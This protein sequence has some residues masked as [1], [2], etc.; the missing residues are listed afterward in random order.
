MENKQLIKKYALSLYQ[1]GK[2]EGDLD[3][4]QKGAHVVRGLYK[5]S[6]TFRYFLLTKK[7]ADNDKK[8]ILSDVLENSCSHYILELIFIII[9][10]KDVKSLLE[11][12]N[13]FF[14]VINNESDIIPVRIISSST[15]SSS[16]IE[17]LIQGIE[18]KLNKKV[19]AKN[20]VD[21]TII[22]GVKLMLGN[23]V[24]D[25]SVSHQLKKIKNTLEQV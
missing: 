18:S 3:E 22:G 19:S 25:G 12:I 14:V 10:K 16:E 21:S 8:K 4:I 15:L 7:I 9:E 24:I 23:K 11:I 6:S 17:S 2:K 5:T 13:R 20:E 1:V